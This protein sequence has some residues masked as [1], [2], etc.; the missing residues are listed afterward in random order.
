MEP[1]VYLH[2]PFEE[3]LAA[4][5]LGSSDMKTLL[6]MPAD[7]WYDSKHNPDRIKPDREKHFILGSA[8]HAILLEGEA[9]YHEQFSVAPDPREHPHAARTIEDLKMLLDANEI[10]FQVSKLKKKSD[11]VE[12]AVEEG[13]G[14]YVWDAI[15]DAHNGRVAA[16]A[17]PLS[18]AEHNA[19]LHMSALVQGHPEIGPGLQGGLSEV[20]VFWHREDEP[21]ILFRARFDTLAKTFSADLKSMS[22]WQG[23]DPAHAAIRQIVELEYDIQATLYQEAREELRKFVKAGKVWTGGEDRRLTSED[24]MEKLKAIATSDSWVWIWLFQQLRDDTGTRPKAPVLI[25]RFYRPS[26]IEEIKQA[27]ELSKSGDQS[28]GFDMMTQAWLKIDRALT[29][30]RSFRDT[31]GFD[32]PWMHVDPN[33]EILD[34]QLAAAGLAHKGV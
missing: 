23:R 8:L 24:D 14:Q 33:H 4:D 10:A 28:G 26:S 7:W 12:L 15:C 16:G 21:D 6:R 17:S 3:Y 30:F 5:A 1:G 31:L 13:L 18:Y 22:N 34:E 27:V 32:T 19:L 11:F 2:L 9:A 29:N 25:P 20:S